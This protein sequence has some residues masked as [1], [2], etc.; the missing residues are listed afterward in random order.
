VHLNFCPVQQPPDF[1]EESLSTVWKERITRAKKWMDHGRGYSNMHATRPS[2]VSLLLGS[3]PLATLAWI[4]EKYLEWSDVDPDL[5]T[6][7]EVASLYWFTE[8]GG[9]SVYSY[10][11]V[12]LPN[13]G[14]LGLETDRAT[15][16]GIG[17]DTFGGSGTVLH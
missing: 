12:G 6:I 2:T 10:R 4:G 1:N 9:K 5:D 7:L 16:I 8:S 14:I 11:Q 15:E 17:E 3:N 13:Y